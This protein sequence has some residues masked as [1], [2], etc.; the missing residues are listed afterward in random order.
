MDLNQYL[1]S[2]S[3]CYNSLKNQHDIAILTVVV[4]GSEPISSVIYTGRFFT[5]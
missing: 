4:A 5:F 2:Y 1:L 3:Q